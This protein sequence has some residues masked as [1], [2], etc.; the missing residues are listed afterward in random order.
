MVTSLN[1]IK[2]DGAEDE[3]QSTSFMPKSTL[4]QAPDLSPPTEETARSTEETIT[5]KAPSPAL[6]SSDDQDTIP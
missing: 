5:M 1:G 4:P 6:A 3:E 2:E